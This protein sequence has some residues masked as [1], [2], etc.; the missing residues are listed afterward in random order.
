MRKLCKGSVPLASMMRSAT[1]NS[2]LAAL[3]ARDRT[4]AERASDCTTEAALSLRRFASRSALSLFS[5]ARRVAA[6]SFRAD[7][8]RID[9][10]LRERRTF[11]SNI[12]TNVITK[13]SSKYVAKRYI[14]V[15]QT[16]VVQ[17]KVINTLLGRNRA[18]KAPRRKRKAPLSLSLSRRKGA[19]ESCSLLA[20]FIY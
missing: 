5:R 19:K 11:P 14:A 1:S 12:I 20:I 15:T 4:E 8:P 13:Y 10:S 6:D 17:N 18:K 2:L 16:H 9:T 7:A 3:R